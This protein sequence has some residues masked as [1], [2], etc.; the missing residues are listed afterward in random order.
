MSTEAEL[1][2]YKFN[3]D[4]PNQPLP[5]PY[6]DF[7]K[8][9]YLSKPN[10]NFV[11]KFQADQTIIRQG[12]NDLYFYITTSVGRINI[13]RTGLS[14]EKEL[15]ITITG[16][17]LVSGEIR[18]LNPEYLRTATVTAID[19]IDAIR[20]TRDDIIGWNMAGGQPSFIYRYL[21]DLADYRLL[22]MPPQEFTLTGFDPWKI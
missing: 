3:P 10:P 16:E 14:G 21:R 7:L 6:L 4:D 2:S 11:A 5:K 1:V 12:D 17:G 20:L 15:D 22:Q 19:D 8:R 13:V 9:M 18:V